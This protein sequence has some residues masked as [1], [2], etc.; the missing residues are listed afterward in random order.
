MKEGRVQVIHS[1][2]LSFQ[3]QGKKFGS[4]GMNAAN[5]ILPSV[6]ISS[7]TMWRQMRFILFVHAGERPPCLEREG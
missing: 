1:F 5:D 2:T 7:L 6:V 4:W 3:L